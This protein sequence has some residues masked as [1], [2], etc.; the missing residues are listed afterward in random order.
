MYPISYEKWLQEQLGEMLELP[1][2]YEALKQIFSIHPFTGSTFVEKA[3][4][5]EDLL[6]RYAPAEL[7]P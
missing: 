1:E 2:V 5:L 4:Q 7:T 6:E 3:K